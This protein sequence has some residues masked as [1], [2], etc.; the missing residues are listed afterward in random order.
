MATNV[1]LPK[2][3]VEMETAR[4]AAWTVDEGAEVSAGEIIANL[5]TDKVVFEFEAPEA[6]V[7]RRVASE[8]AELEIGALMAVLAADRAE[9]DGL[10]GSTPPPDGAAPSASAVPAASADVAS[11][12]EAATAGDAPLTEGPTGPAS[13]AAVAV[14]DGTVRA[15]PLARRVARVH[16]VDLATV[17]GTGPRGAIRRRD[18]EAAIAAPAAAEPTPTEA[19]AAPATP[20]APAAP[21]AGVPGTV[22]NLTP[23]RRTIAARMQASLHDAAQMTDIREHDVSALV[24]FRTR[25]AGQADRL[26]YKLS[27][28]DLITKAAALALRR[29]PELN[30]SLD[31]DRL[32]VYDEINVGIAVAIPDGLVVPVVRHADR[33]GLRSLH[34]E[35]A[36]VIEL[37][38]AR[39]AGPDVMTGGTFTVTNFGSYGSQIGTPILMPGQA[40]ILGVG[41]LVERPVVRDGEIVVGTAMYTSLTVDHR[42]VDGESAGRYQNELGALLAD[43]EHLLLQS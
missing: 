38:R 24:A 25:I 20:A 43:P 12:P 34:D 31:G 40:A 41:A 26:G 27:Y 13:S 28:T 7:L 14:A 17:A 9:Y 4:I 1:T 42:V 19:P 32:T 10:D 5:E 6:G 35:M 18:V 36:R 21:P 29:V 22:T 23:M 39:T 2:L 16:G 11:V 30:A 33:L 8:D 37:A 15:S 3:G